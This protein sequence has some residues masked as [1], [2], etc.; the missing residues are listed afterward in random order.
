MLLGWGAAA[1]LFP[2]SPTLV[3]VF[4]GATLSATSVG[5]TVRVLKDLRVTQSREGQIILGAAILDDVLGLVVLALV[6]GMVTVAAGGAGLSGL[7]MVWILLRALLF[8]GITIGVGHL[9]SGP[10]VRL[11]ARSGQPVL[12]QGMFAAVVLM[13]LVTTLVTP[14][15]LRWAFGSAGR[16]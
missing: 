16:N 9:A 6:G 15:G 5:I 12:S 11:A 2:G 10:I 13:V 3:H 4:V 7:S 1:W 14:V 8:L